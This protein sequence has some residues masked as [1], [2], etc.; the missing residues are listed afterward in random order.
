MADRKQNSTD[1]CRFYC[2]IVNP[3]SNLR[4]QVT[5]DL[6]IFELLWIRIRTRIP[7]YLWSAGVCPNALTNHRG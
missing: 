7:S 3:Q 5:E 2:K 4:I 1:L 6:R